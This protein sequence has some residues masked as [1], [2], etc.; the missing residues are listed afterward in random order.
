MNSRLAQFFVFYINLKP[1]GV[2]KSL[3]IKNFHEFISFLNSLGLLNYFCQKT[4]QNSLMRTEKSF[5]RIFIIFVFILNKFVK[6]RS[7]VVI[8][9]DDR[10]YGLNLFS[11]SLG[12]IIIFFFGLFV[13]L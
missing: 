2:I 6:A 13:A 11:V 4:F 7:Y 1:F 9:L 10:R 8:F 5:H 3:I 12:F